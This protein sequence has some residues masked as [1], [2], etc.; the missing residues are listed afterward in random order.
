MP[1]PYPAD[2][3]DPSGNGTT[4]ESRLVVFTDPN[5]QPGGST[6]IGCV[7]TT[8]SSLIDLHTG[9]QIVPWTGVVDNPNDFNPLPGIPDGMGISVALDGSNGTI[10]TTEAG[11]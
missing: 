7:L 6:P 2:L 1:N 3:N 10:T 5:N 8:D 11:A 4:L 9:T